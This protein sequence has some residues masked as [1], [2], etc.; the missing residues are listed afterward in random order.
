MERWLFKVEK[1]TLRNFPFYAQCNQILVPQH[2]WNYKFSING[3]RSW[4][5]RIN[6]F[7]TKHILS[8]IQF[9]SRWLTNIYL[10]SNDGVTI[11]SIWTKWNSPEQPSTEIWQLINIRVWIKVREIASKSN[12]FN[13]SITINLIIKR[14]SALDIDLLIIINKETFITIKEGII[15]KRQTKKI[16]TIVI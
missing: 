10:K 11:T 8:I 16:I 6:K 15:I 13:N 3:K 2:Y 14:Q 1:C 9:R 7:V 5:L 12:L 4:W